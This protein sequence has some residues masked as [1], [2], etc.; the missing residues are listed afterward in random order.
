MI[1]AS[2]EQLLSDINAL[3]TKE[4][5]CFDVKWSIATCMMLHLK[6]ASDSEQRNITSHEIW[7]GA[8]KLTKT[9]LS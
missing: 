7:E 8:I 4:F 1:F 9:T 3:I 2:T 5:I 6:I